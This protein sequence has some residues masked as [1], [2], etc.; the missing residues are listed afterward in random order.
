M[1]SAK[2]VFGLLMSGLM[3][4]LAAC[5][6]GD[7]AK[8]RVVNASPDD[9]QLDFTVDAKTLASGV[10]YASPT[11]Y[12]TFNPGQ[13]RIQVALPGTSNTLI[14]QTLN[15]GS[16]SQ[17]TFIAADFR[18][19]ITGILLTDSKTTP[20]SGNANLRLVQIAPSLGAVDVYVVPPN[21]DLSTVS[22]FA[23]HLSF[24]SATGY[25]SLSA[26]TYQILFTTPDSIFVIFDAGTI[27]L[28]AGQNRTVLA[29]NGQ[30]GGFTTAT[31]KDL[32]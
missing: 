1:K 12:S 28:T 27:S 2:L 11:D 7:N 26:G 9:P 15:L 20:T 32:N 19:D 13:R 17:S 30:S 3:L 21:T 22:P 4:V 6:G 8:L 14:D 5:G 31:L 16:G 29:L 25:E 10:G 18:S 24:G 23:S